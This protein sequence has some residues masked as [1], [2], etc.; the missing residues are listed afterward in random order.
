MSFD[1]H[2]C[3][4]FHFAAGLDKDQKK[5]AGCGLS[6]PFFH[7]ISILNSN[8]TKSKGYIFF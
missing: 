7:I 3:F 1:F 8:Y 5:I 2:D 4:Y 6:G